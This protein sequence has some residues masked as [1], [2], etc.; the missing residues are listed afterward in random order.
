M[1]FKKLE[2]LLKEHGEP[3]FRLRQVREAYFKGLKC[4]WEEAVG[5]PKE[6]R[7]GLG[8]DLPWDSL[9][10]VKSLRDKSDKSE[11]AL[12]KAHDGATVESVL[13]RHQDGRNTVCVSSQIG[14][15]L[16]C[17][18]CATGQSGFERNLEPHEIVEQAVLFARK[19]KAEN[20]KAANV[21]FMGMGEPFL[22]YANVLAA[23]REINS[24]GGLGVAARNIS[25]STIGIPEGIRAL[26]REK[27]QVNLAFSLHAPDSRSR[28]RIV[29][30][31]MVY[32]MA[33]AFEAID[34]YIKMTSRR[35]MIEYIL[36][37]GLN[38]SPR[39]AEELSELLKEKRLLF[40]N[41]IP[42]NPAGRHE[43]SGRERIDAFRSVLEKG[44]IAVTV[45]HPFGGKIC[46]ACGQ[47]AARR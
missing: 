32:P 16:A 6:L 25:I 7:S 40:V 13:I 46:G 3:A 31:N 34:Y 30:A 24:P 39:Q 14:C 20:A 17:V 47:L 15:P 42:Y 18:F 36:I 37:K 11:K 9:S 28:S 19:L 23:V 12:F 38:D 45:R 21:V 10:L 33:K 27:L 35:V 43:K 4:G 29:P 1:D 26:A 22:N 5:L 2:I 41:L 44:R 8:A